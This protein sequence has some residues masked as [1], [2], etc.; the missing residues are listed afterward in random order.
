LIV[1]GIISAVGGVVLI[2]AG[3]L[4][5]KRDDERFLNETTSSGGVLEPTVTSTGPR[6]RGTIM[7]AFGGV[8]LGPLAHGLII[9]GSFMLVRGR[10]LQRRA[11]LGVASVRFRF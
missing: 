7:A 3:A 5:Q 4:V 10:N 1:G 9:P 2:V 6:Y 8:A 11:S